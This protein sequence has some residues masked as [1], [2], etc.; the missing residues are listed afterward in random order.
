MEGP[1]LLHTTT[2][3]RSRTRNHCEALDIAVA[4][5]S[6]LSGILLHKLSLTY[7]TIS[8]KSYEKSCHWRRSQKTA[9][10][11]Y[12]M[13]RFAV[14]LDKSSRRERRP[15][16]VVIGHFKELHAFAPSPRKTQRR[17]SS[18]RGHASV[19]ALS[20]PTAIR[21]GLVANTP[22]P[23]TSPSNVLGCQGLG[24]VSGG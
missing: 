18:S 7:S 6:L 16:I 9:R 3:G 23:A 19:G 1:T 4:A 22:G 8:E 2:R 21:G 5:R 17:G 14:V 20:G 15:H 13:C 24:G 12:N 10:M 11:R